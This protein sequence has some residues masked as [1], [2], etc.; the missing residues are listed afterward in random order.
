MATPHVA[1]AA[2]LVWAATYS[3]GAKLCATNV[4]VRNRIEGR[5]DQTSGIATTGPTDGA[6]TPLRSSHGNL[7][8]GKVIQE[9]RGRSSGSISMIWLHWRGI[10]FG[11]RDHVVRSGVE[12][13]ADAPL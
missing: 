7:Q 6:S 11:A 10:V 4:C 1:G 2:S 3:S 8:Q 5:A 9:S 13:S 12:I